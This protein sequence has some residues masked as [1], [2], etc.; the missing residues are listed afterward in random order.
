MKTEA[1]AIPQHIPIRENVNKLLIKIG[2]LFQKISSDR[3]RGHSARETKRQNQP[4][5]GQCRASLR[6]LQTNPFKYM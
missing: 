2:Y 1:I 4:L 3:R 5:K 6:F